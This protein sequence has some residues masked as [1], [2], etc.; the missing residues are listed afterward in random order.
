MDLLFIDSGKI[1]YYNAEK[2]DF[3]LKKVFFAE[4]D[5]LFKKFVLQI[6]KRN[7]ANTQKQTHKR[8]FPIP[9][10]SMGRRNGEGNKPGNKFNIEEGI[11]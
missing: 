11:V 1:A 4:K 7:K 3:G 9:D 5:V 8:S 6:Q 10:G 2:G